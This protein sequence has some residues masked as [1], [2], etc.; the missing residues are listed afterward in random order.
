MPQLRDTPA[1]RQTRPIDIG[2]YHIPFSVHDD[3]FELETSR[4]GN[5]KMSGLVLPE[6]G[7]R[8]LV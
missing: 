6:V 1:C 3:A 4:D 8:L 5:A 2:S 7:V